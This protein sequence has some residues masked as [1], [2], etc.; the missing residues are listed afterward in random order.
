M[1][2]RALLL[3][4]MSTNQPAERQL[5]SLQRR[6]GAK[7][8]G[9]Q[10]RPLQTHAKK[11]PLESDVLSFGSVFVW[12]GIRSAVINTQRGQAVEEIESVV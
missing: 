2:R 7:G 8:T 5:S 9:K 12:G 11:A 1:R 3:F 6:P 10:G 4:E